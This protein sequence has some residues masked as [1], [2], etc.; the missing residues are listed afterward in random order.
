[1]WISNIRQVKNEIRVLGVSVKRSREEDH[2]HLVGVVFRGGLWLDGVLKSSALRS[3]V[4][5][6]LVDMIKSSPH[7]S[8]VRVILLH[9]SLLESECSLDPFKLSVE[10]CRPVILLSKNEDDFYAQ[11]TQ[12]LVVTQRFKMNRMGKTISA[13]SVGLKRRD[14]EK[15]LDVSTREYDLPEALRVAD[16]VASAITLCSKQN[17]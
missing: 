15:I 8:Q 2:F 5:K 12:K 9:N 10:T 13:L 11:Y 6:E 3:N 17:I 4:T 7:H 1:M 14:A 16:L